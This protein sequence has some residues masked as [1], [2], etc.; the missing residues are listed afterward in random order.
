VLKGPEYQHFRD[1]CLEKLREKH[2]D[3]FHFFTTQSSPEKE[4]SLNPT[5][6]IMK[7]T[8][9][10]S[11]FVASLSGAFGQQTIIQTHTFGPSTL[12]FD[13]TY[14]FNE[15]DGDLADIISVN[16][17]YSLSVSDGQMNI[18]NDGANPADVTAEFGGEMGVSS[19]DYTAFTSTT[20]QPIFGDVKAITTSVFNLTADDGNDGPGDFSTLPND[21]ALLAGTSQTTSGN[22]DVNAG[23]WADYVGNGTDSLTVSANSFAS[24]GTAS[25]VEF[26]S[27]PATGSGFITLTIVAVPEP[28]SALLSMAGLVAFGL[29]RRR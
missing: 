14:I 9:A 15:Y 27:V 5:P 21:G 8:I 12:S 3:L 2:L 13:N 18:D 29:R 4:T 24:I 26:G 10:A 25:G 17:S 11:V 23:L 20:F 16:W 19:T 6:K 1:E 28:S 22:A 7:K